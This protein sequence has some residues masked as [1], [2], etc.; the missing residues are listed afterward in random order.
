VGAQED[1]GR[2]TAAM[3]V[4]SG[5]VDVETLSGSRTLAAK[6]KHWAT[7]ALCRRLVLWAWTRTSEE[8]EF[9]P[10]A[11]AAIKKVVVDHSA[12]FSP[13][14]PLVEPA[15]HRFKIARLATALAA[16]TFSTD[17]AMRKLIVTEGHVRYIG[18]FLTA[19]YSSPGFAYDQWSA[20]EKAARDIH[21]EDR[22]RAA[23]INTGSHA[24]DGCRGLLGLTEVTNTD[25]EDLFGCGKDGARELMA[26]LVQTQCLRRRGQ[27]RFRSPAFNKFLKRFSDELKSGTVQASGADGVGGASP[28]EDF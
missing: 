26:V 6:P 1:I 15:D 10:A 9:T 2:F 3:A 8:I 28:D 24:Y 27:S 19:L 22:V 23:L 13:T 17:D 11:L 20:I 5:E 21:G 14:I 16:R 25:L 4:C 7:S 12:R 18:D